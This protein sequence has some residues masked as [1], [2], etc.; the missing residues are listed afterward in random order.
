MEGGGMLMRG[1]WA[2]QFNAADKRNLLIIDIELPFL[3]HS[4]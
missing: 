3:A 4:T 1:K 2:H